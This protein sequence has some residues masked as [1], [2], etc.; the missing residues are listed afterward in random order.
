MAI[1]SM[2]RLYVDSFVISLVLKKKITNWGGGNVSSCSGVGG[3]DRTQLG[4]AG[5]EA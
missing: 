1:L 4:L 2:Y 3:G 5:E